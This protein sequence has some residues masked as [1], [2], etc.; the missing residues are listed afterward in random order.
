MRTSRIVKHE[1]FW[2]KF[3][4]IFIRKKIK[5]YTRKITNTDMQITLSILQ[6]IFSFAKLI[7]ISFFVINS[8]TILTLVNINFNLYINIISSLTKIL[9][10]FFVVFIFMYLLYSCINSFIIKSILTNDNKFYFRIEDMLIFFSICTSLVMFFYFYNL[11]LEI[12]YNLQIIQKSTL[13]MI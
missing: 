13:L 5:S 4:K 8:I 11:V 9:F 6:N 3:K 10:T 12:S 7:F 1:T 2:S